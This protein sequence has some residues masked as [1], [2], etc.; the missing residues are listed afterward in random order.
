MHNI[1][2]AVAENLHYCCKNLGKAS[3][4]CKDSLPS[5]PVTTVCGSLSSVV[6]IIHSPGQV[7]VRRSFYLRHTL[8]TNISMLVMR[9]LSSKARSVEA[10]GTS[11]GIPIHPSGGAVITLFA[12]N[13]YLGSPLDPYRRSSVCLSNRGLR[14]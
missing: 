7:S 5:I 8:P 11:S 14:R 12:F 1:D 4:T 2:D 13:C 9:L 6:S 10:L 3:P